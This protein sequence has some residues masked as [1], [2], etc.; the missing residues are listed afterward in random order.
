MNTP[1]TITL[2]GNTGNIYTQMVLYELKRQDL[3]PITII[4][5]T[6][7]TS[8]NSF[9]QRAMR[10]VQSN[11][12]IQLSFF[13][14]LRWKKL[15]RKVLFRQSKTFKLETK[16][17]RRATD[18]IL[19]NCRWKKVSTLDSKDV[20]DLLQK[21]NSQVGILA[22]LNQIVPAN[23]LSQFQICLNAH[24][25]P[26]PECRGGG[27][28]EQT[29][30]K[31]LRPAAS[32]HIVTPEIDSGDIVAKEQ[33]PLQSTDSFDAVR[34]KLDIR[35]SA[36][37]AEAVAEYLDKGELDT[38]PNNGPLHRWKDCTRTVQKQAEQNLKEMTN[39]INSIN[40]SDN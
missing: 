7:K 37:L 2:I 13:D 34:L 1:E 39:Q 27:A 25:A 20:E 33:I 23:I 9:F 32:V 4:D 26:L 5:I 29:L 15:L 14:P 18:E 28:L 31:G 30:Y 17:Y 12:Y 21:S 24:P 40:L 10:L 36:M 3:M 11:P 22:G 16:K 35:R 6:G 19:Q 38:E 8:G